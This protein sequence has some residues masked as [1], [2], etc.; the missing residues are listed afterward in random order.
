MTSGGSSGFSPGTPA[1]G[2]KGGGS[3]DHDRIIAVGG[4]QGMSI[5]GGG[6]G[7]ISSLPL[8]TPADMLA[9]IWVTQA[10]LQARLGYSMGEM[11]IDERCQYIKDM[12]LACTDELHEALQEVSW[13]PWTHGGKTMNRDAYVKELIDAFHFL[14]NLFLVAGATPQEIHSKYLAKNKVNH[15]RQDDGYDGK[16]KCSYCHRELENSFQIIEYGEMFCCYEHQGLH[17]AAKQE[18]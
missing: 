8:H 4:S 17:K 15:Q 5:S 2:G 9:E 14:M 3:T 7:G 16:E 1:G 10:Q 6:G 11:T 18:G 13:K 12:V